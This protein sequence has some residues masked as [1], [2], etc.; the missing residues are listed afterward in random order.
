[1][2]V[3]PVDVL[4][5]GSGWTSSFLLPLLVRE[6]ISYAYTSRSTPTDDERRRGKIQFELTDPVTSESLKSLPPAKT[7]LIVFPIK[8]LDQVHDL[9]ELYEKQHGPTRWIQLGSTG[10]WGSGHHTSSSPFDRNNARAICEQRLL[11][12]TRSPTSRSRSAVLNLAGLYGDQRQPVN[13]AARVGAQKDMLAVKG[14][15]H[16]V[17]GRDVARAVLLLH[18]S[19]SSGWGQRWIV[20]D[21]KVYDWWQLFRFLKPRLPDH[22]DDSGEVAETWVRE[23]MQENNIHALPRP[24]AHKQGQGLPRFLER[25]LDGMEFWDL[26]RTRPEADSA[27][28]WADHNVRSK[29]AAD[30]ANGSSKEWSEKRSSINGSGGP[31]SGPTFRPVPFDPTIPQEH[32]QAL[33]ERLEHDIKRPMPIEAEFEGDY[34]RFGLT[35]AKFLELKDAW[36][37]FLRSGADND[38]GQQSDQLVDT[39]EIGIST[40]SSRRRGPDHDTWAAEQ[41]HIS[42]FSH[43]KVQIE[44]VD[45]HFIHERANPPPA[46]GLGIKIIPLLLLHGWP[47]SFHE[48]LNVIKPLAHPGTLAKVHFDVVVP[49]HPGYLFS[50]RPRNTARDARTGKVVGQHSGPNGDLLV[51]DVARIMDKLMQGLGYRHYAVQAGD[52]GAAVL[53]RMAIKYPQRVKAVHLNFCPSIAPALTV[54][55]LGRRFT[56]DW[57]ATLP[58]RVPRDR[59]MEPS[60]GLLP[61]KLGKAGDWAWKAASL[62]SLGGIPSP[63][64]SQE[65][66]RMQRGSEFVATGSAYAAMHATKPSTLGLVVSGSPLSSL[67]WI[68]EKMYAW[69]DRDPS[70]STILSSLTLYETTQTLP[71]SFYP[72]RNRDPRGPSAIASDPSNYIS[73]PTGFSNFPLEIIPVPKSFVQATVNL[74]W[75]SAKSRGG[76]FAAMEEPR[77]FVEDV[78]DCFAEIWPL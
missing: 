33:I 51:A 36:I 73:Q 49:S 38:S 34:E 24:L 46:P 9:V 58:Q 31:R 20:S 32:I 45:L 5:L 75:Y 23:L 74:Q 72:Y 12:L 43:Y 62:L 7:I 19:K 60:L 59:Y 69:T 54:P 50:S 28:K 67:A 70:I 71:R 56:P 61:G 4:L 66:L 6:R 77:L 15:V 13:F 21:G 10:I 47:G 48:F 16:F 52:W 22:P 27:Y 29:S 53:R 64:S 40:A 35:H 39:S 26:F 57:I 78:A 30:D 68:G 3:H 44:D 41:A 14:S 37:P 2:V 11:D 18:Q 55:L 76:H 1:M 65:R 25:S 17:H 42:S 8:S 63:P